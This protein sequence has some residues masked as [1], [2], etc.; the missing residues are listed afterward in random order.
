[1]KAPTQKEPPTKG[2]FSD[3][4]VMSC[5]LPYC[6]AMLL[7]REC[8]GYWREIQSSPKHR[9]PYGTRVFSLAAKDDFMAYLD[10]IEKSATEEHRKLVR[11]IY[12]YPR[13]EQAAQKQA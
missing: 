3:V 6:N 13:E 4:D 10:E 7:D 12:N 5:L 1:M 9:L 2:F 8:A 11:D